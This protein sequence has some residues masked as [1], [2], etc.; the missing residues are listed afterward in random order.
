ME[1]K[2][3]NKVDGLDN[4]K[5]VVKEAPKAFEKSTFKFLKKEGGSFIGSKDKD[6]LFRRQVMRKKSK[7][8]NEFPLKMAR[9]FKAWVY[10]SSNSFDFDLS[11]GIFYKTKRKI[12]TVMEFLNEGGTITNR[13]IM[14]IPNRRSE[15]IKRTRPAKRYN[16][17]KSMLQAKQLFFVKKRGKYFW[18]DVYGEVLFFGSRSVKVKQKYNLE[19]SWDKRKDSTLKR[20]KAKIDQICVKLDKKRSA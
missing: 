6:G 17:F 20:Y 8:G 14:P 5:R 7:E 9:I 19:T 12:H 2:L 18:V 4:F 11:M 3:E 13:K 10:D 15:T 16:L 1:I